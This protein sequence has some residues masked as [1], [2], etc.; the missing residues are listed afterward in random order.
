MNPA[1]LEKCGRLLFGERW[2]EPMARALGITGTSV[3][4]YLSGKRRI[5]D[6]IT[7]RIGKLMDT[8]ID[9]MHETLDILD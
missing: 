4:R 2:K 8:R 1:S 6:D 9:E 5:P 7:K 3:H